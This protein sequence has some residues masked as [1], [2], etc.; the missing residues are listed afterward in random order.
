MSIEQAEK[1]LK[2]MTSSLMGTELGFDEKD[3][4]ELA[5]E[6]KIPVIINFEDEID[7]VEAL[8]INCV[9][10]S[11]NP[12][13]KEGCELMYEL[14]AGNYMWGLTSGG[15]IG[16]DKETELCCLTRIV[17]LPIEQ[18]VFMELFVQVASA[19]KYWVE[20]IE[21]HSQRN[22]EIIPTETMMRV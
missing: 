12:Q 18:D 19:A 7:G 17:E 22:E 21:E 6:E 1:L 10:G 20:R 3:F 9:L 11:V 13:T 5:I 4:L 15:V 8:I 16:I 2:T 14:L